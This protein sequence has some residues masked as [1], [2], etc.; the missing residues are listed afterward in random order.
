M[1]SAI[2]RGVFKST[3]EEEASSSR[4]V[5]SQTSVGPCHGGHAISGGGQ[6]MGT[7]VQSVVMHLLC[8]HP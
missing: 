2:I 3:G 1:V 8:H 6:S 7:S 5:T 4:S